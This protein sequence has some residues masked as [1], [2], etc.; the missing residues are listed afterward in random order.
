MSVSLRETYHARVLIVD[1]NPL[2][3]SLHAAYVDAT[4]GF[5]AC[6]VA[7]AAPA[8]LALARLRQADLVLLDLDLAEAPS[9]VRDLRPLPVL[10]VAAGPCLRDLAPVYGE[11]RS[12]LLKPFS[13]AAL[14]DR[15]EAHRRDGGAWH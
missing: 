1:G 3:A 6:G 9:L 13:F 5:A 11:V 12:V 8:A 10:G 7:S 2:V 4:E 15:L 14:R